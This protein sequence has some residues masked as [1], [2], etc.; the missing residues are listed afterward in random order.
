M[1]GV[2]LGIVFTASLSHFF[3]NTSGYR[4]GQIDAINGIIKYELKTNPDKTVE[5]VKKEEK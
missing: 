3:P 5:W 2:W 1:L 4:Q